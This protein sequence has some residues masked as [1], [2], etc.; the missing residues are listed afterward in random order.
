MWD[1]VRSTIQEILKVT[2]TRF[3]KLKG[4][5]NSAGGVVTLVYVNR[6]P[7]LYVS[8]SPAISAAGDFS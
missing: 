6:I 4:I 2:V 5:P 3:M 7:I 8:I 1:R